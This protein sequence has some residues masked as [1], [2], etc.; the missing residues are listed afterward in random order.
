MQEERERND[1]KHAKQT[2]AEMGAQFVI[3]AI[4]RMVIFLGVVGLMVLVGWVI[5]TVMRGGFKARVLS[6]IEHKNKK[7]ARHLKDSAVAEVRKLLS[8]IKNASMLIP[9]SELRIGKKLGGG[10]FG[11]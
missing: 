2:Q 9:L 7:H 8:E 5:N 1:T 11:E 3:V 10:Y 6:N 4:P